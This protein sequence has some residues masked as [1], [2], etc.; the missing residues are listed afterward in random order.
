MVAKMLLAPSY[1]SNSYVSHSST[2]AANMASSTTARR[3]AATMRP[4]ATGA[5]AQALCMNPMRTA[6]CHAS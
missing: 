4:C 2:P 1:V 3:A 6:L 5:L